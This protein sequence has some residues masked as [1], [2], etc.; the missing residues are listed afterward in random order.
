MSWSC[1]QTRAE[2]SGA[3]DG[4]PESVASLQHLKLCEGCARH[5]R[6]LFL[7]EED[8][9]EL[10]GGV[11][12]APEGFV[13]RL[14][15]RLPAESP[16][17][18]RASQERGTWVETVAWLVSGA[19]LLLGLERAGGV[20][21]GQEVGSRILILSRESLLL[22][23]A[24]LGGWKD[25]ATQELAP[26]VLPEPGSLVVLLLVLAMVLHWAALRGSGTEVTR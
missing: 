5:A 20:Q 26:L 12:S 3:L 14:L 21:L 11:E 25:S 15:E 2:L 13:L 9:S 1:E 8:L 24:L 10:L 17:Q 22:L 18:L 16:S 23:G 7:L 19:V 6:Q 4:V